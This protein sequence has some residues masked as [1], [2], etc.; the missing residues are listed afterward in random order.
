MMVEGIM[1]SAVHKSCEETIAL[2]GI[3]GKPNLH[4]TLERTPRIT[5]IMWELIIS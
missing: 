3:I 1:L 5:L 2:R 4:L